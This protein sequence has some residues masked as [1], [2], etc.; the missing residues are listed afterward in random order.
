MSV[1]FPGV[2][3]GVASFSYR[4]LTRDGGQKVGNGR[5]LY[6]AVGHFNAEQILEE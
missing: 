4:F 2:D 3:K 6:G 1:F 5:G